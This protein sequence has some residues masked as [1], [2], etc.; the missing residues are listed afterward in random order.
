MGIM[1]E[2]HPVYAA[3]SRARTQAVAAARGLFAEVYERLVT[4]GHQVELRPFEA[5]VGEI[6]QI[7]VLDGV[8][9]HDGGYRPVIEFA[10]N[11]DHW[12]NEAYFVE[13]RFIPGYNLKRVIGFNKMIE[14]TRSSARSPN[15]MTPDRTCEFVLKY[16]TET[17]KREAQRADE[18]AKRVVEELAH[19]SNEEVAKQLRERPNKGRA[20]VFT[21]SVATSADKLIVQFRGT[22]AEVRRALELLDSAFPL[23]QTVS[24]QE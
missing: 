15:A 6:P 22:E 12:S 19:R 10:V 3:R 21:N 14:V 5:A 11:F 7:A 8:T 13:V 9:L 20:S 2:K 24:S 23:P 17:R 16:T 1:K 18:H 4:R